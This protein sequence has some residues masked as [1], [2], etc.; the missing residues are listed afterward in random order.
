[1]IFSGDKMTKEEL[2]RALKGTRF[3]D[4]EARAINARNEA[5][6]VERKKVHKRTR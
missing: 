6:A 5:P 4:E 1:M 3:T 2:V